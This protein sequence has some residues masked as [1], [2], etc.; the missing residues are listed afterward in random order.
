MI[1]ASGVFFYSDTTRRYLYLLRSDGKNWSLPGGKCELNETLADS[2]VRECIEEMNYFPDGG[3][4]V[5]IQKFVN[6]NFTYNTFFCRV[7]TEFTPQLNH[8]HCG[9]AWVMSDHYPKPLHPGLF[10]TINFHV[11][12]DKLELLTTTSVV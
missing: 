9:Y 8:E 12:R 6:Q 5:P 2:V 4:L 3:K 11:V 10:N 1:T 7:D